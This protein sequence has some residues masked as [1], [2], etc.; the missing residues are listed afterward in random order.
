MVN[1]SVPDSALPPAVCA[2]A[3]SSTAALRSGIAPIWITQPSIAFV[4]A[5]VTGSTASL[6]AVSTGSWRH[7]GWRRRWN[8]DLL[9][10]ERID[11]CG[12]ADHRVRAW[13]LHRQSARRWLAL[14]RN[15]RQP[16]RP[17]AVPE[18]QSPKPCTRRCAAGDQV[19]AAAGRC[20]GQIPRDEVLHLGIAART[21]APAHHDGDD[22]AVAV[23]HR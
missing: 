1:G 9:G 15:A 8:G 6:A 21:S 18:R 2:R 14:C 17:S 3:S 13:A 7:N 11:Q 20:L 16:G 19:A 10:D 22:R 23:V 5:V 12:A 4:D